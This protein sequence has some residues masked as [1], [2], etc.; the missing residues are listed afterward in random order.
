LPLLV[1]EIRKCGH[2]L[3][4]VLNAQKI[5]ASWVTQM[6]GVNT[7]A[8]RGIYLQAVVIG[9][10]LVVRSFIRRV[11]ACEVGLASI[12]ERLFPVFVIPQQVTAVKKPVRGCESG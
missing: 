11:L 2:H 10:T 5:N 12:L 4:V 6:I 7:Y 1:A 3:R 8:L 9:L